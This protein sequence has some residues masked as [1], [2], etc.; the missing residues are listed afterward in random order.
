[1]SPHADN[2]SITITKAVHSRCILVTQGGTLYAVTGTAAPRDP[3]PGQAHQ[4]QQLE[5][6]S[7]PEPGGS[8]SAQAHRIETSTFGGG[9]LYQTGLAH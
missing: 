8:G 3:L 9:C 6:A 4:R 1:M 2:I 5:P 7:E